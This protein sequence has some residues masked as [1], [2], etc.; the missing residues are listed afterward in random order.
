MAAAAAA[1]GAPQSSKH[2]GGTSAAEVGY[3]SAVCGMRY[4][5]LRVRGT[6]QSTTRCQSCAVPA[7]A[8]AY[9]VWRLAYGVR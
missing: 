4:R 1:D 8:V 9:G 2:A 3:A 5:D 7:P 6:V